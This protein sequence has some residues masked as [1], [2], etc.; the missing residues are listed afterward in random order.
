MILKASVPP[1]FSVKIYLVLVPSQSFCT[2][3]GPLWIFMSTYILI[4]WLRVLVNLLLFLSK[5]QEKARRLQLENFVMVTLIQ[6]KGKR[7]MSLPSGY[8]RT[9]H[10]AGLIKKMENTVECEDLGRYLYPTSPSWNYSAKSSW[11]A[12]GSKSFRKYSAEICDF[13]S[14]WSRDTILPLKFCNAFHSP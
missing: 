3:G 7:I 9:A 12:Q 4:L 1:F 8:M 6:G 2:P 14:L 11:I 5:C 13:C 10:L